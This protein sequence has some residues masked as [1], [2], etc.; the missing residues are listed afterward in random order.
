MR[1]LTV[2]IR[3]FLFIF[4]ASFLLA[5]ESET[6]LFLGIF[7]NLSVQSFLNFQSRVGWLFCV[8]IIR[9]DQRQNVAPISSIIVIPLT[10]VIRMNGFDKYSQT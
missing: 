2:L 6:F 3:Q 7:C 8:K 5:K 10:V 1:D 4:S 9:N